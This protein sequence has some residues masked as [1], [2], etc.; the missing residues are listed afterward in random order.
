MSITILQT[1]LVCHLC[2]SQEACKLLT[3]L[4]GSAKL[5]KELLQ[6]GNSSDD[7]SYDIAVTSLAT[8]MNI[9]NLTPNDAYQVLSKRLLP[10]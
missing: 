8:D 5:F 1:E 6:P 4:P 2:R 10:E 7:S 9:H 3:T